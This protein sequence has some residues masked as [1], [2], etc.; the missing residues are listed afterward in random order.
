MGGARYNPA[1]IE[2]KM[3]TGRWYSVFYLLSSIRNSN[4]LLRFPGFFK[5]TFRIRSLDERK[6]ICDKIPVKFYE[7]RGEIM[8]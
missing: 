8:K 2:E 6:M 5:S 7:M 4:I 1:I 3:R